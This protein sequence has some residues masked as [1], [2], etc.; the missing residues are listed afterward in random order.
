LA[1][2]SSPCAASSQWTN[3]IWAH[4]RFE[5]LFLRQQCRILFLR[6]LLLLSFTTHSHVSSKSL[7]WEIVKESLHKIRLSVE[8][9]WPSPLRPWTV[10]RVSPVE[11]LRSNS[12]VY[13]SHSVNCHAF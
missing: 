8:T 6:L 10:F 7:S 2:S 3:A 4:G 11:K 5:N 1:C 13:C 9:S 12:C